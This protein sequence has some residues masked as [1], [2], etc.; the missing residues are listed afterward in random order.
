MR[1]TLLRRSWLRRVLRVETAEG[2]FTVAYNGRGGWDG[3][4]IYVDD[5]LAAHNPSL[6]F[7]PVFMFSLGEQ[8]AAVEIR[9]WP[10]LTI[11]SF[12]LLVEDEVLYAEGTRQPFLAPNWAE[13]ERRGIAAAQD[14]LAK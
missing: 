7:G 13:V 2:A 12:H 3:E 4:A 8:L 11:R 14:V 9:A 5:Q 6:W 1:A 10:W